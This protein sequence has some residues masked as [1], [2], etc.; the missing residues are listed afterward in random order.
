MGEG[1][2][3]LGDDVYSLPVLSTFG[4]HRK[5]TIALER[6]FAFVGR[7]IQ[8]QSVLNIYFEPETNGFQIESYFPRIYMTR[9][10]MQK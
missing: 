9:K 10:L 7:G 8:K 5:D 4:V 6:E 2:R 1:K 3:G